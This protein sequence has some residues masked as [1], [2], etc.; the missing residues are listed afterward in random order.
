M[1]QDGKPKDIYRPD[2]LHMTAPGYAIWTGLIK[3][4]LLEEAARPAACKGG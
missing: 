1:L 4:P 2:G 3:P